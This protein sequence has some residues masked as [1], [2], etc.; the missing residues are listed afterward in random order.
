MKQYLDLLYEV[1]QNGTPKNDRT[2]VGT[3][4]L[5]GAQMRF[6][7]S[8]GFPLVTTKQVHFKSVVH[9]LLWFLSGDTNVKYLQDNGVRIWNEWADENGD[10]GPV[11]GK[12][13]RCWTT[14]DGAVDQI[15]KAVHDLKTNPDSRRIIVSAWNVGDLDKMALPPCH[16]LF[17]FNVTNG[18]LNCMVT[19]RSCDLFLGVPFNIASYSLL[20]LM[21]AQ[22]C[23]LKPGSLVWSGGD[24]HV[25]ANHLQQV[26]EQL[27]RTPKALP[28]VRFKR[29]PAS[30]FDYQY[31][32]IELCNYDPYPAIKGKVAV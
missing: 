8:K 5:F 11:Y 30:I 18:K 32:D 4:S 28:Q 12:Q 10:L 1:M 27:S 6:D 15:A 7:L 13:W 31:E 20:T 14:Q 16:L 17:Q 29:K 3:L 26:Q 9:E 2:G 21:I 24:I 22:Q 23:N 25:Y 19:Q